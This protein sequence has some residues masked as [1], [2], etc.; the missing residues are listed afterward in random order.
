MESFVSIFEGDKMSANRTFGNLISELFEIF[1]EIY[2]DA[3]LAAVA[4]A[5]IIDEFLTG[6]SYRED[7][8]VLDLVQEFNDDDISFYD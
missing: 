1:M 4:T 6:R 5:T 7:D 3:D 8:N 2:G